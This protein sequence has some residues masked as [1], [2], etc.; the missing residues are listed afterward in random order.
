MEG[1]FR[2]AYEREREAR[3]AHRVLG[4]GDP[5]GRGVSGARRRDGEGS[6]SRPGR[7]ALSLSLCAITEGREGKI[8][9]GEGT[10]EGKRLARGKGKGRRVRVGEGDG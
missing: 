10:T 5:F 7:R 6:G 8:K 9:M 4:L 3:L 1:R 2:E